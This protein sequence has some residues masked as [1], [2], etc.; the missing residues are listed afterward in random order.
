MSTAT[1]E[2]DVVFTNRVYYGVSSIPDQLNETFVKTLSSRLQ[3]EREGSFTVDA[4][5]GQYIYYAVPSEYGKCTFSYGGFV[6]GF[7]KVASNIQVENAYKETEEYD[8]YQSDYPNLGDAT[9]V[10]V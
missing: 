10:V 5:D 7:K 6:G 8:V 1:T 2:L 9:I 3:T 4:G